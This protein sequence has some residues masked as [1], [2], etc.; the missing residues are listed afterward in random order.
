MV[1]FGYVPLTEIP[2]PAVKVTV[3]S[4]AVLVMVMVPLL[5]IGEPETLM[6]VP[7]LAATVYG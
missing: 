3:W 6:P 4:G 5:V 1:K 7:A 2:V